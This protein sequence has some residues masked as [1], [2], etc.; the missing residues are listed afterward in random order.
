[1]FRQ[2]VS[3]I[4]ML[5]FVTG[6]LVAMPH[7]HP[8]A[9]EPLDHDARPHIHIGWLAQVAHCH[10]GEHAHHHHNDCSHSVA[11][12]CETESGRDGHDRDAV[13]LA[14]DIGVS[15]PTSGITPVDRFPLVTT[16]ALPVAT[17]ATSVSLSVAN[18]FFTEECSSTYPLCL[19]VRALRI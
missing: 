1:M 8:G 3:I 9:S 19:T 2:S 17:L 18:A 12:T 15:L 4:V 10:D 14:N 16:F 7:V 11:C 5:G 6:Q 13:Y